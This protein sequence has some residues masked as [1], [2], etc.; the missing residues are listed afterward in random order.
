M[1]VH[2]HGAPD[3]LRLDSVSPPVPGS[4]EV[5]V[6]VEAAGVN[7][8]DLLVV[9]GTYQ[10]LP[11][12]PFI[13]GKEVAGEIM[14]V[15]PGVTDRVPGDRV[16]AQLEHG[17]YAT[18][19][20]VTA[21][22]T[23]RMPAAMSFADAA[24]MG[25]VYQTAW[26]A[27]M[28]RGGFKPGQAVLVTGAAGGVGLAVIQLVHAL[29]GIAIA[30]LRGKSKWDVVRA[31]GAS[32]MVDLS[33]PELRD[34]V[35]DQIRSVTEGNGVD[36]VIDQVGGDV[37]DGAIRSLAWCGRLVVVGFAAGRIPTLKMNYLLVK[38][39]T[40]TGLQWSDYRDRVPAAVNQA[41]EALFALYLDGRIKPVLHQVF[42]L[43]QA[44]D[45]LSVLSKGG[46]AGKI[47]LRT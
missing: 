44:A 16:M 18:Q 20:A 10:V 29:G 14:A 33:G 7:Y 39:I 2:A 3:V 45:A 36:L 28:E 19:V 4:G 37:F 38:N 25:L 23:W 30:G 5:T 21:T 40:V 42:P 47:L 6:R 15:G 22:S 35:R 27:L 11:P 13:P 43:E 41:Q 34:S 32:H 12:C 17:A 24:A 31:S 26:F 1:R 8:P 46:I 9:A